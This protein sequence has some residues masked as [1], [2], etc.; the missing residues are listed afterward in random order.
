MGGRLYC[1][2]G[3]QQVRLCPDGRI[4]AVSFTTPD[5]AEHTLETECV[6]STIPLNALY[7]AIAWNMQVRHSVQWRSLRLLYLITADKLCG[8]AETCYFPESV[9]PFG[10]VSELTRYSPALN[11]D[12]SRSTLTIEIPCSPG[13]PM[14]SAPDAEL[15]HLCLKALRQ[16][17]ALQDSG[18]ERIEFFSVQVARRLSRIRTRLERTVRAR[19]LLPG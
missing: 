8:D 9:F 16:L 3:V 13:D 7:G 1:A 4:Q 5:G 10:R 6:V 17:Q 11:R 2:S 19:L 12:D 14:W 18:D 15:A